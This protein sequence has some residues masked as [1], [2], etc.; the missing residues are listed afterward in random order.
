MSTDSYT[1]G[2]KVTLNASNQPQLTQAWKIATGS[3]SPVIAN[4][5]LYAARSGTVS[6]YNPTT[7]AS[8]WSTAIGSIHWESPVVV[9]GLVLVSDGSSHLTAFGP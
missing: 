4:G 2:Y 9:D 3:T 7:G 6:A 8:L 1:A 5:V